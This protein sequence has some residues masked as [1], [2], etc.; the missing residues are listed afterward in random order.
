MK[1]VIAGERTFGREHLAAIKNIDSVE[2]A[3]SA[4][5]VADATKSA[6]EDRSIPHR[7]L[8]DGMNTGSVDAIDISGQCPIA[9]GVDLMQR[10]FFPAVRNSLEPNGSARQ[11]PATMEIMEKIRQTVERR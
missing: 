5:G 2:V 10:E 6:A 3:S 1:V 8:Y 11:I 4:G 9:N 7:S